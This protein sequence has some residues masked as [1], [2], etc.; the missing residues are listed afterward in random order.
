[1]TEIEKMRKYI[2]QTKIP[3]ANTSGYN[4]TT[5]EVFAL[6]DCSGVDALFESVV[7][8]FKYGQAKSY[9]AAKAEVKR[10]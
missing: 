3:V 10:A 7:L 9:R 5:T 6:I 2:E 4:M 1:M 8:A